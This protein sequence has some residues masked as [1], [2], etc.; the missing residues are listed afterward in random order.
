MGKPAARMNDMT[1]HGSA[2]VPGPGSPNVRIGGQPAW[3]GMSA[4]AV[5]ALAA[6]VAELAEN[7]AKAQ[8]KV[9]A[10]AGTAAAPAAQANLVKT[11]TDGIAKIA[12]IL[13]GS[14]ADVYA[15]PTLTVLIPH[16]PGVVISGSQT[17]LANGLPTCRAG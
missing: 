14:G 11:A 1:G 13:A 6:A 17:V 2:L 12:S 16:G 8:A 7:L 10:A 9:T 5:A 4:A 3:R 15:C